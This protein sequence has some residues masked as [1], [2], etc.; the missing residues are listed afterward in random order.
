[1]TAFHLR[2]WNWFGLSVVRFVVMPS[3]V[4]AQ[5]VEDMPTVLT[6]PVAA[7]SRVGGSAGFKVS[8]GGSA[9]LSFLWMRNGQ[10]VAGA[11]RDFL[12][13]PLVGLSDAG[14]YAVRVANAVGSV[15]SAAAMLTVGAAPAI[16]IVDAR[17][18]ADPRLN[19]K[20]TGSNGMNETITAIFPLPDGR[21]VIA[22]STGDR[23][24]VLRLL[25]DGQIDPA[26]AESIVDAGSTRLAVLSDGGLLVAR[27]GAALSGTD[28]DFFRL[29]EDGSVDRS[30]SLPTTR[31][32]SAGTGLLHR[33]LVQPDGKIV[34]MT[35][36]GKLVRLLADGRV[37]PE[38][39]SPAVATG[40]ATTSA[41]AGDIALV[42]NGNI[43]RAIP[44]DGLRRFLPNGQPDSSFVSPVDGRNVGTNA[45]HLFSGADDRM[46]VEYVTW[47]GSGWTSIAVATG[48]LQ[49]L[50][51][52]SIGNG[53]DG[54]TILAAPTP[55]G[56]LLTRPSG[57]TALRHLTDPPGITLWSSYGRAIASVNLGVALPL[58]AAS[59]G[60][61]AAFGPDSGLW[62]GGDFS[63]YN[64][65]ATPRIVRLNRV[66]SEVAA[67]P[68]LLGTW[69]NAF[70]EFMRF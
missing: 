30:F 53:F 44:Y 12:A 26:F 55:D 70:R 1:M 63:F 14:S 29:L 4:E 5:V 2:S 23:T 18:R 64:G 20:V 51:S 68:V 54:E 15:T 37:D 39:Q 6:Q 69:P 10:P 36:A 41:S 24:R 7:V 8:A 32:A 49:I 47:A 34:V 28:G 48:S 25:A 17:F 65:V 60:Y 11:T 61:V 33:M 50:S 16:P 67:A 27:W 21:V 19:V 22:L 9:P 45:F 13:V 52:G 58:T 46:V 57:Y 66:A 42:R 40:L 62:L 56:T 38:F 31:P 59:S 43:Y 3:L 35:M